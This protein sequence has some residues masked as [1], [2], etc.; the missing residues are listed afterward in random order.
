[1]TYVCILQS[2]NVSDQLYIGWT[3]DLRDRLATHNAGKSAPTRKFRPRK[4]VFYAAFNSKQKAINFERY[5]KS[6]S[7][8]VFR[9][10]HL[11]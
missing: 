11:L 1:V 4:I 2:I 3:E 7:G 10:R 6:G 8:T 9:Q 5:L